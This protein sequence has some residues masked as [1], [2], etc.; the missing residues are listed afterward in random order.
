VAVS[1]GDDG[2]GMWC[3]VVMYQMLVL[4]VDGWNDFLEPT[5]TGI[6]CWR[7]VGQKELGIHMCVF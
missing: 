7:T 6:L 4:E 3:M 5:E 2:G 1:S